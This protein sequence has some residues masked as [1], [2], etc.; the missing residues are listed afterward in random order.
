M[1]TAQI[2]V[3][4]AHYSLSTRGAQSDDRRLYERYCGERRCADGAAVAG[5]PGNWIFAGQPCRQVMA[6]FKAYWASHATVHQKCLKQ[7]KARSNIGDFET[8]LFRGDD[9]V[10]VALLAPYFARKDRRVHCQ[11]RRRGVAAAHHRREVFYVCFAYWVRLL[12]EQCHDRLGSRQ[13]R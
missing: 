6:A 9:S 2:G 8:R 12:H 4:W 1:G 7:I 13:V 10:G 3:G 11:S 5:V